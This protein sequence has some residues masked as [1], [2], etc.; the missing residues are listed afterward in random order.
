MS[1]VREKAFCPRCEVSVNVG[2]WRDS[3]FGNECLGNE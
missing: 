3:P 1:H 2:L